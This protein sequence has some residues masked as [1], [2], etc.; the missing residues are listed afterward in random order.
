ML[1]YSASQFNSKDANLF[2]QPGVAN[3]HKAGTATLGDKD[4]GLTF[5]K[6][7]QTMDGWIL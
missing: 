1:L 2:V 5:R 3:A 7:R 4:S 6:S